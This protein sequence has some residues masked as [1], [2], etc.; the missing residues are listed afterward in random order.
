M[1]TKLLATAL[2][3]VLI[4]LTS[5][6][7]PITNLN[8]STSAVKGYSPA[9]SSVLASIVLLKGFSITPPSAN[10]PVIT[11]NKPAQPNGTKTTNT[12]TLRKKPHVGPFIPPVNVPGGDGELHDPFGGNGP[13]EYPVGDQS[14]AP[15]PEPAT[16]LL[17]GAGLLG[18]AT[19][20]KF[21]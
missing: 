4:P 19:V 2:I 9:P 15:V 18:V 3:C 8:D 12:S 6:A 14:P 16:M 11:L 20:K 17:L 5:H 7:I 13:G 1:R 21:F 10:P